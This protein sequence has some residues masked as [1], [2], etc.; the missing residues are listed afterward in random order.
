[1]KIKLVGSELVSG[2]E[3]ICNHSIPFIAL[4]SVRLEPVDI[5]DQNA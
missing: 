4:I 2:S 1:M 5:D 3:S